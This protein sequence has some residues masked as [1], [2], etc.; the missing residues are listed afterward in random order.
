[1]GRFSAKLFRGLGYT[2]F[3]T[4]SHNNNLYLLKRNSLLLTKKR[5]RSSFDTVLQIYSSTFKHSETFHSCHS[6]IAGVVSGVFENIGI[7]KGFSFSKN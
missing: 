5:A 6:C 4:D 7:R 3:K 1:M 2:V